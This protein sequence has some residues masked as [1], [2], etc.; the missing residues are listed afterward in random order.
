MH[1]YLKKAVQDR[2][3]IRYQKEMSKSL[4][5]RL[6]FESIAISYERQGISRDTSTA[7]RLTALVVR[8]ENQEMFILADS[9]GRRGRKEWKK[10]VSIGYNI[11]FPLSS[12]HR[13]VEGN[14]KVYE[15]ART[16]GA[17]EAVSVDRLSFFLAFRCCLNV[18]LSH[19]GTLKALE[20]FQ[21]RAHH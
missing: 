11:K 8:R 20:H 19:D 6:H 13:D 5:G 15:D 1:T 17:E 14:E 12:Y 4:L 18:A 21:R 9:Q 16:D 7:N 10:Y 2:I 3:Y